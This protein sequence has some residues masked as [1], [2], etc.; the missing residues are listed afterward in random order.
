MSNL[1]AAI[2]HP[3]PPNQKTAMHR[4]N[5][6]TIRTE[7]THAAIMSRPR[8]SAE[9]PVLEPLATHASDLPG[10]NALG[11]VYDVTGP[12]TA[13]GYDSA[14]RDRLIAHVE[15]H[16]E[17][18]TDTQ[19]GIARKVGVNASQFS[20][21]L[22]GTPSGDVAKLET[23]VRAYLETAPAPDGS[24]ALR[25]ADG[26]QPTALLHRVASMAAAA[27]RVGGIHLCHCPAGM[28]RTTAYRA[29]LAGHPSALGLSVTVARQNA[30]QIARELYTQLATRSGSKG[31]ADRWAFLVA[32]LTGTNRL[33]LVDDAWRLTSGAR[34]WLF[35]L[36][37]ATG[38]PALLL[39]E[40]L[41]ESAPGVP[42]D[43][44]VYHPRLL[45]RIGDDR[46][47]LH[48]IGYATRGGWDAK[49]DLR[50][51]ILDLARPYLGE[52]AVEILPEAEALL[53]R[54]GSGH[55][56]TLT[57]RLALARDLAEQAEARSRTLTT[58]QS[59]QSAAGA[60]LA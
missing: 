55:L 44:A 16:R 13:K 14:L 7:M 11:I 9:R 21:Y 20:R 29:Y 39:D 58:V 41:L 48:R 22:K 50:T 23:A 24:A 6:A 32:K 15:G 10:A 42:E 59:W 46:R 27:I 52:A 35:D 54:P 18:G 38:C 45:D 25:L 57:Q 37:E 40:S 26:I 19:A 3:L 30:A 49:E 12:D 53:R 4:R 56:R 51:L 43:R 60:M 17:A 31:Y 1:F 2:F 8:V 33:L 28:G 5:P 34:A 36:L 47:Q